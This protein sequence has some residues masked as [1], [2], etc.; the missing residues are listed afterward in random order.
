LEGVYIKNNMCTDQIII[1]LVKTGRSKRDV[2]NEQIKILSIKKSVLI[3]IKVYKLLVT[4]T[5]K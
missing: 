3:A 2:F 4:K 5:A 1:F